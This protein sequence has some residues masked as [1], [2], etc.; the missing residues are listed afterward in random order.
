MIFFIAQALNEPF[1]HDIQDIKLNRLCASIAYDLL[2]AHSI[3]PTS[4]DNLIDPHHETPPWLEDSVKIPLE[5]LNVHPVAKTDFSAFLRRLV[6]RRGIPAVFAGLGFY[7]VWSVFIVLLTWRMHWETE[8]G[9]KQDSRPWDV[10]IP[11]SSATASFVSLGVFLILGFWITDAYNR[12]WRG[13]QLWLTGLQ[14]KIQNYAFFLAISFRHGFWHQRD[15][16]RI[17]SHLVALPYATKAHLRDSRDLSELSGILSP[18]DLSTLQSAHNMPAHIGNVLAA[19]AS[20]VDATFFRHGPGIAASLGNAGFVS[21][22]QIEPLLLDIADCV[23]IRKFP[24]SPAFTTHLQLFI[25][26]W[27]CI[28]PLSVVVEHGFISILYLLPIGY[29]IIRMLHIGREIC[30]PFGDDPDDIPL[31]EFCDFIKGA[32]QE[33]YCQTHGGTQ[34]ILRVS[35]YTR[36]SFHPKAIRVRFSEGKESRRSRHRE[37]TPTLKSSIMKL[38]TNL[39]SVPLPILLLTVVWS[40]SATLISWRL[41]KVWN[42]N[43]N[44]PKW[45]S[46]VDVDSIVLSNVG[47]ALFLIL[48]F[49]ASDGV[50]RYEEGAQSIFDIRLNLLSY[51]QE[52]VQAFDDGRMHIGD[53]ERVVAHLVEIPLRFRDDLLGVSPKGGRIS[54]SL[55]SDDDQKFVNNSTDSIDYLLKVVEAYFITADM[56][57]RT[58]IYKETDSTGLHFATALISSARITQL[59]HQ[60]SKIKSVKRFPVVG[61]YRRHQY[62]FTALWLAFLPFSMT[63]QT[64]FSTILWAPVISYGIL[65]LEGLAAKLVDPFGTD[66]TD[67]DVHDLFTACANSILEM[68]NSVGWECDRH[69][70]EAPVDE[71][72][73]LGCSIS[74]NTVMDSC[75]LASLS[76]ASSEDD[77]VFAFFGPKKFKMKPSLFAHFI[78]SLPFV[79]LTAVAVWAAFAC[80]ISNVT[81][82]SSSNNLDASYWWTSFVSINSNVMKNVS[83]GAF[84]VLGF[85]VRAAFGRYHV[86]GG[87]WGDHLRGACHTLTVTFLSYWPAD[88]MHKGDKERVIGH[89]ATLPIAL[90]EELRH[91]HDLREARGLLS[92]SDL[93]RV[94]YAES[95][96]MHCISVI[97]QYY[98]KVMTRPETLRG[99]NIKGGFLTIANIGHMFDIEAA[100]NAAL[101]LDRVPIAP[102]FKALV[103]TLLVIFFGT[104]PFA[105][106]E[107]SGWLSI[108]WT[109][110]VAYGILG[111]YQ[112]AKELENPFGRDMNDL[113]LDEMANAV[114]ADVLSA[115]SKQPDGFSSV[116]KAEEAHD[117]LQN[118]SIDA[119][120]DHIH[121]LLRAHEDKATLARIWDGLKIAPHA[122]SAWMVLGIALWS[123]F[124]VSFCY[125]QGKYWPLQSREENDTTKDLWF[126]SDIAIDPAVMNYVGYALFLLLAFRLNDSHTRYVNAVTVWNKTLVGELRIVVHRLFAGFRRNSWHENDFS[127]ISGHL[128]SFAISLVGVLRKSPIENKLQKFL[129]PADSKRIATAIHGPDYCLDVVTSYLLEA[130]RRHSLTN[131]KFMSKYN[132]MRLIDQVKN[133]SL[134]GRS[135]VRIVK[136][137]LPYG[138]VQHQRIFMVIWLL[139]FPLSIVESSGWVTILW[140]VIIAYGIIGIEHWASELTDP[141]GYD[142]SDLPLDLMCQRVFVIIKSAMTSFMNGLEPFIRRDRL[143]FRPVKGHTFVQ[144]DRD[145]EF[146]GSSRM[147]NISNE[148]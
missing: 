82:N 138:Y 1:G 86:A 59:R 4:R 75:T 131:P 132:F 14:P 141:F 40:L 46:P 83:F 48:A 102:G 57:G 127:R 36:E 56:P 13:L 90:K 79:Q 114:V 133:L 87:V 27:L 7:T 51:A 115:Y 52:I 53:K 37:S 30:D 106:A 93:A 54:G 77:E 49:R 147:S 119:K 118:G 47:F 94:Q 42:G 63:S 17:L 109:T 44:C 140:T 143:P 12:Y 20:H 41:S 25:V 146:E 81:R 135:C 15:R 45:C 80:F 111:M 32:I 123:G 21:I 144:L 120:E 88:E 62:I 38:Y 89:I 145:H 128:S 69:V 139:L 3:S 33:T 76:R 116:I 104:L 96:S 26:F 2:V 19:Y 99:K 136:V 29:S 60:I 70:R 71:A 64:G 108:L 107:L 142:L 73:R 91:S 18:R 110:I 101:F 148:R 31:D 6:F 85:Y 113:D 105:I 125:I 8:G 43:N 10:D 124:I 122:M 78:D 103:E 66:E 137:P 34:N 126:Q 9:R 100:V 95:M 39:P 61:S 98:Y 97:K 130:D 22:R 50:K 5:D 67:L 84:T 72:P 134:S 16:E 11:L 121:G 65:S 68:V 35:S 117:I 74:G 58:T 24:I 129:G 55:L 92:S 112:V 23:I 28:L